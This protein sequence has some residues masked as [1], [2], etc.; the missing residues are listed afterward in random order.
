MLTNQNMDINVD[1]LQLSIN[2]L[3]KKT[4]GSG[5]ENENMSDQQL[6]EELHK[7]IIKKFINK[8]KYNHLFQT[9]F[10]VMI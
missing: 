5:L 7:P 1:L 8:K 4:S 6:V 2:F 10:V 9:I 3:I